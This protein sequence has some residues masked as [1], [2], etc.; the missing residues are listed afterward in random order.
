MALDINNINTRIE[1]LK[2]EIARADG[3]KQ[4]VE[5]QLARDYSVDTIE[6]AEALLDKIAMELQEAEK[7]QEEYIEAAD[8]LLREAGL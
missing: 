4:S 2:T 1:R 8:K 5:E 6:D 7:A 3:Q